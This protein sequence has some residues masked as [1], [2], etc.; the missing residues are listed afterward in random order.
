MTSPAPLVETEWLAAHLADPGVVVIEASW[1]LGGK[2]DARGEFEAKHI[3]GARFFDIEVLSD[4][5]TD[6]PHMMPSPEAFAAGMSELGISDDSSVVVYDAAGIYSAP[7]AWWMLRA[8]GHERVAVLNGGFPKWL[9]EGRPVERGWPTPTPTPTLPRHFIPKPKPELIRDFEGLNANLATKYEQVV[10]ARSPGRFRGEEAEPRAGLRAGH[11]PGARNVYYA[12]LLT[13]DGTMKSSDALRG[14]FAERGV[15][16]SRPAVTSC[17]SGI[18][19]AVVMLALDVA[20]A[21][22]TA[23][24]DGSWTDWGSRPDA[25]IA[26]GAP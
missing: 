7:R 25:P 24:Y 11:I 4:H 3:P 18:T 20:G 14:I 6:L 17:G 21:R 5:T 2:R 26:T 12:D 9:R 10:D 13:A 1:H 15:D 23:L 8:M 22:R 16:L 19:A